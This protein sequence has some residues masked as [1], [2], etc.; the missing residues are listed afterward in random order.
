MERDLFTSIGKG[1][2]ELALRGLIEHMNT[3]VCDNQR[4]QDR[5][6]ADVGSEPSAD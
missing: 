2:G 3:K 6:I 5:E 1:G 4:V